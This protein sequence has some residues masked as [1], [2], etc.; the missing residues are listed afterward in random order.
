MWKFLTF[1]LGRV[2]CQQD[3]QL[4]RIQTRLMKIETKLE[5]INMTQEQ[6]VAAIAAL[7]EA[8]TKAGAAVTAISGRISGLEEKIKNM[9]LDAAQEAE[10]IAAVQAASGSTSA[11]ADS[12]N[13]MAQDAV[14]PVPTPVPVG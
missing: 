5:T 12:L 14:N 1:V 3:H 7:N 4:A 2:F 6:A 13:A 8:T 10:L 9:G 11:L